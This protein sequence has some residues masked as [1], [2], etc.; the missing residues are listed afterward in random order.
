MADLL[1]LVAEDN[2]VVVVLEDLHW[3]DGPTLRLLDYLCAEI[4]SAPIFILGTCRADEP[5]PELKKMLPSLRRAAGADEVRLGPLNQ[6]EVADFLRAVLGEPAVGLAQA[7]CERTEG[8]P[9]FLVEVARMLSEEPI[10]KH[11]AIL[12]S[13]VPERV[14]GM[15]C[16]RLDKLTPQCR[17]LLEIAAVLGRSVSLRRLQTIAGTDQISVLELIDEAKAA[18]LLISLN[19]KPEELQFQHGLFRE[20]LYADLPMARRVKLHRAVAEALEAESGPEVHAADLA[21]HWM[22]AAAGG[23]TGN[24]ERW[25]LQAAEAATTNLAFEAAVPL[26]IAALDLA[27]RR[28]ADAAE[29]AALLVALGTAQWRSGELQACVKSTHRAAALAEQAGRPD[30]MAQAALVMHGVGDKRITDSVIRLCR[31]ALASLGPGNERLKAAL[32][33]RLALAV[34]ENGEVESAMALSAQALELA[35]Q[36]DDPEVLGAALEGRQRALFLPQWSEERMILGGRMLALAS[37][38]GRLDLELWGHAWRASVM[39]EHGDPSGIVA[40]LKG[41]ERVAGILKDPLSRFHLLKTRA[42]WQHITGHFQEAR[43]SWDTALQHALRIEDRS[44]MGLYLGFIAMLARET[45]DYDDYRRT[46]SR[47]GVDSSDVPPVMAALLALL[48]LDEGAMDEARVEYERLRPLYP[49]EQG[50]PGWL[51]TTSFFGELA[52]AFGDRDIASSV[53]ATLLPFADHFESCGSGVVF[54]YAPVSYYLGLLAES[55][56]KPEEARTQLQ[57][58]IEFSQRVGAPG[59]AARAQYALARV[60]RREEPKHAYD[61]AGSATATAKVLGMRPLHLRATALVEELIPAA[62]ANFPLSRRECEV[63]SLVAEGLSNRRIAEALVVS[64]RTVESHVQSILTKLDFGSRSQVAAW[65]AAN[66]LG[67]R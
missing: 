36:F 46:F 23:D 61:L 18:S 58:A 13:A 35:G 21:F 53:Y 63:A 7:V 25:T 10:G 50:S 51:M 32:M 2:D 59:I 20:A 26:Y 57:N 40:E 24:A 44:A 67:R 65:A 29:L 62:T 33:G 19:G 30:L 55:L 34:S 48:K 41:L 8:H 54:C 16:H 64:P 27:E 45:G 3:A 37:L 4:A 9:L 22:Q 47:M 1:R 56:D 43:E 39:F 31:Q 12:T 38:S 11:D 6:A 42:A 60:I 5:G 52:T 15:V 17:S 66:G 14:R 28:G 49:V